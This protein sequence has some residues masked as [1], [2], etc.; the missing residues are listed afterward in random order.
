MSRDEPRIVFPPYFSCFLHP[1]SSSLRLPASFVFRLASSSGFRF[2]TSCFQLPSSSG[3]LPAFFSFRPPASYI[4]LLYKISFS[5]SR[6]SSSHSI[7]PKIQPN[8]PRHT[9]LPRIPCIA[10]HK[11]DMLR[12]IPSATHT[13]RD[14]SMCHRGNPAHKRHI[15]TLLHTKIATKCI[16]HNGIKKYISLSYLFN[17][18]IFVTFSL[19]FN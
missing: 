16:I 4:L 15:P 17:I 5:S 10:A 18:Q 9:L 2:P 8:H 19:F 1:A 12:S 7:P 13:F 11:R 6:P 3:L 14:N